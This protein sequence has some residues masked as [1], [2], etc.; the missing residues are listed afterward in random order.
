MGS[1]LEKAIYRPEKTRPFRAGWTPA[2]YPITE[3]VTVLG[4]ATDAQ[5]Q[6][7]LAYYLYTCTG[8]R[9]L[10]LPLLS[11]RVRT[12]LGS[13]RSFQWMMVDTQARTQALEAKKIALTY[14]ASLVDAH[15][16]QV[17][18]GYTCGS[19][20]DV[21][22]IRLSGVMQFGFRSP[23]QQ[24][25]EAVQWPQSAGIFVP[26]IRE[27][28]QFVYDGYCPAKVETYSEAKPS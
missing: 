13:S 18:N 22:W 27:G 21:T 5:K 23:V 14:D 6:A 10:Y 28:G 19:G 16:V 3:E 11:A 7:A 20:S 9:D 15:L 26:L 25:F 1:A 17:K 24:S 4:K 2:N 12:A 8:D